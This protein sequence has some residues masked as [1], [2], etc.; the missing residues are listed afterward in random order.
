MAF[1]QTAYRV[2]SRLSLDV[3]AGSIAGLLFFSRLFH[4]ELDPLIA[5]LLGMAVWC[6]YTL[7]HILD[8]RKLKSPLSS[9][10]V[11]YQR[12]GGV[13]WFFVIPTVLLGLFLS[14][15]VLGLG[16]ELYFSLGLG[17]VIL[18]TMFF[19]RK[20]GQAAGLIKELSTA[21]FYVLGIAW[22]P[23][24]RL[25]VIDW[26]WQNLLFIPAYMALAFLNLLMF[27][28]LDRKED[29]A[30]GFPS[31]A[32]TLVPERLLVWIRRLAFLLIFLSLV[33]FILLPS[34]Y[35]PFACLL[36]LMTLIHYLSFFH[37][38]ISQEAKRGRME[39]SFMLPLLLWML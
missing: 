20:A 30:L 29:A 9:R 2:I 37:A 21:V 26:T 6:I 14:Y 17:I 31:A 36:L 33:A 27:S 8:A 32:L 3:V 39:A 28:F 10:H 18:L 1:L 12:W 38:G 16:K 11:F 7:D 4:A 13:L 22:I 5:L 23:L 25:E 19:L 34:F 15:R 24:L 35:R